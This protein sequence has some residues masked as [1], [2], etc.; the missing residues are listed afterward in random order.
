MSYLDTLKQLQENLHI[1][2]QLETY[3]EWIGW[4]FM[5]S[6]GILLSTFLYSYMNSTLGA[7]HRAN[8]S[9]PTSSII[10]HIS[11]FIAGIATLIIG[12]IGL[13]H[14]IPY[15]SLTNDSE[16]RITTYLSQLNTDEYAKLKQQ[17][18]VN[19]NTS[20]DDRTTQSTHEQ[21]KSTLSPENRRTF[22][23]FFQTLIYFHKGGHNLCLKNIQY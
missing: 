6:G 16:Q 14:Y 1:K 22:F 8:T 10:I 17:V 2:R 13:V 15:T 4:A 19:R 11:G 18:E 9:E 7:S 21:L 5:V 3:P 20:F 12:F 23:F